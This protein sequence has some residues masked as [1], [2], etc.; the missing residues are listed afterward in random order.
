MKLVH[1]YY[2]FENNLENK[3]TKVLKDFAV[4]NELLG[5]ILIII[6]LL[7]FNFGMVKHILLSRL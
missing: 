7:K 4:S 2:Q 3:Q 5:L 6:D 1:T